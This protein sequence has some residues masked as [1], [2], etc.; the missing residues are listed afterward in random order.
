[1]VEPDLFEEV[2]S[3]V[4]RM[5]QELQEIHDDAEQPGDAPNP[6]ANV[7]PLIEEWNQLHLRA[8]GMACEIP[9]PGGPISSEL[10]GYRP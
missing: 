3:L 10:D 8:H 1:M 7:L 9:D 2:L 4:D 5:A 6:M